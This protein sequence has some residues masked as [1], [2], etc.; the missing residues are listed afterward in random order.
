MSGG[1]T[2]NLVR[3][4]NQIAANLAAHGA[5]AAAAETAEHIARYWD[6]RMR[7]ALREVDPAQL[8]AIAR[9]AVAR[10]DPAGA[11]SPLTD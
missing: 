11:A 6:P 10:L 1:T 5:E 3:M 9:A 7:A 4:A 8:S 2:A